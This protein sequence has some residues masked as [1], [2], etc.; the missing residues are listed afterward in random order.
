MGGTCGHAGGKCPCAWRERAMAGADAG[1]YRKSATR[2]ATYLVKI[3]EELHQTNTVLVDDLLEGGQR[4]VEVL[5]HGGADGLYTGHEGWYGQYCKQL[6]GGRR[7]SEYR[8]DD[9][10]TTRGV[11][12]TEREREGARVS[13]GLGAWVEQPPPA[14]RLDPPH[15]TVW[16]LYTTLLT[17][18]PYPPIQIASRGHKLLVDSRGAPTYCHRLAQLT[19]KAPPGPLKR[20]PDA[21]SARIEAR[22]ANCIRPN[23]QERYIRCRIQGTSRWICHPLATLRA[24]R[25][26]RERF[27]NPRTPP[28]PLSPP[29]ELSSSCDPFP[30]AIT[31]PT[32]PLLPLSPSIYS[33][34]L[35]PFHHFCS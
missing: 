23:A 21:T 20:L 2:C 19:Q 33:Y 1:I 12:G 24:H 11:L 31:I 28:R 6:M 14:T 16:V 4:R 34:P 8:D 13:P 15:W 32:T 17:R 5:R 30:H 22:S 18:M 35:S 26:E 9:P 10:L 25:L 3:T 27:A 7:G 29:S